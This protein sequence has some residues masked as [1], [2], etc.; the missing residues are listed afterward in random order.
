MIA[1][2]LRGQASV[3]ADRLGANDVAAALAECATVAESAPD[4]PTVRILESYGAM[5]D[6]AAW[7]RRSLRF[8]RQEL[9][10]VPEHW[11]A[12]GI[13]RSSLSGSQRRAVNP[14]NALLNYLYAVAEAETTIALTAFGCDPGLGVLHADKMGRASLSLD[15]LE[16]IRPAV[17]AFL[18][19][20]VDRSVLSVADIFED[21]DG[22]CRLMPNLVGALVE[23]CGEWERL[24]TPWAKRVSRHFEANGAAPKT[25]RQEPARRLVPVPPTILKRLRQL[26]RRDRR[27]PRDPDTTPA[28][29]QKRCKGCGADFVAKK[30]Q[31]CAACIPQL[32]AIG[33]KAAA[34]ALRQRVARGRNRWNSPDRARKLGDARRLRSAENPGLGSD[35][36][37]LAEPHG[38]VDRILPGLRGITGAAIRNATG[39]SVSY[40]RRIL[41]GQYVPHPMH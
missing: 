21:R 12:F 2:K 25:L 28:A 34:E 5:A 19:D 36:P 31:Y 26:E 6:W 16:A 39:L 22:H 24:V 13:R 37:G 7:E 20:W 35:P 10:R 40:C 41:R 4:L 15:V 23:T 30:N 27:P 14:F 33:S 17:D 9:D 11:R 1:E 29:W 3:L 38:F 8:P 32:A 18:L